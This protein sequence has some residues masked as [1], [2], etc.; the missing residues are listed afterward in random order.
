MRIK[1]ILIITSLVLLISGCS[2]KINPIEPELY[3]TG[4]QLLNTA[5]L[6]NGKM[7]IL[8]SYNG[9]EYNLLSEDLLNKIKYTKRELNSM[10]LISLNVYDN[11]VYVEIP[12]T[13]GT[14][15]ERMTLN[16]IKQSND[17]NKFKISYEFGDGT[18]YLYD[19]YNKIY[20]FDKLRPTK[21]INININDYSEYY[22]FE[23]RD[24]D[25][26]EFICKYCVPTELVTDESIISN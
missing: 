10:K 7:E 22:V 4:T 5:Q 1:I 8:L 26:H 24:K 16:E 6:Y 23:L 11:K 15:Y 9:D 21:V 17:G 13:N 25:T 19:E 20:E 2:M 14:R 18:N 12:Y 3:Y